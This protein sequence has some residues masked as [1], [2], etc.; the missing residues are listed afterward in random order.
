MSSAISLLSV[1]PVRK[2]PAHRSEMVSQLLFGETV[3]ILNEQQDFLQISCDEDQY[4]GWVQANQLQLCGHT[5][6][7]HIYTAAWSADIFVNGMKRRIPFG[8]PVYQNGVADANIDYG[9]V[10]TMTSGTLEFSGASLEKIYSN[11]LETPYLWGGRSVFGI[12][13]SGFVQQV[14]K[15]FGI[16]LLRDA[17]LQ[18]TQGQLVESLETARV[19]DLAFFEND[20]GKITH[21]GII[22]SGNKI[23]HASG[24]VRIDTINIDGITNVDN[25]KRT[26]RL[27][28]I[29]RMLID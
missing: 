16:K 25:G 23:V 19:G 29:R 12:D 26:H 13:C 11:F 10:Q 3:K 17:Y 28:G 24:K 18:A 9:N 20:K 6:A 27:N 7:T 8:S 4:E 14:F 22:L 21:V 15:M 5:A 2:E 1:V